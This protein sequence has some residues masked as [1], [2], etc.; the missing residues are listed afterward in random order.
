MK[1]SGKMCLM[2]VLKVT[3]TRVSPSLENTFLEKTQG[4]GGGRI[5]PTPALLGSKIF[6]DPVNPPILNIN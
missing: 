3:K 4:G 6:W 5:D 2:I 1:F